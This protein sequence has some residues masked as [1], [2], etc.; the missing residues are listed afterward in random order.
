LNASRKLLAL[1]A[2]AATLAMVAVSAPAAVAETPTITSSCPSYAFTKPF[3]W[4]KDYNWYALISGQTVDNFDGA[5]WTLMGGASVTS[6]TIAGGK[7]GSVLDLPSGSQAVSPAICV[8]RDFPHARMMVRNVT[9][10]EGV[11]FYVSYLGTSTWN[12]PKNTG[13]VHGSGT[14]WT[15]AHPIN[16]QPYSVSGYQT[17]RF[18]FKPGGKTSRFQIYNAYVDPRSR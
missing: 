10:A 14:G 18:T 4:V 6:T 5:G 2:L 13:Q 11:F 16:L 8:T 17:V 12:K 7:A 9:G 3:S 1:P 15:A